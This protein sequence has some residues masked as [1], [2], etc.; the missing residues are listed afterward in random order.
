MKKKILILF[1]LLFLI[2]GCKKDL[3]SFT[4]AYTTGSTI[5]GYTSSSE[6]TVYHDGE[7][8]DHVE[9]LETIKS[10]NIDVLSSIEQ[11]IKNMYDPLIKKYKGYSY[12]ID[13]SRDKII[14]KVKI[15]YTK[16]DI[17]AYLRD[18]PSQ[19]NYF[20]GDK[21]SVDGIVAI[22]DSMGIGCDYEKE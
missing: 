15:D 11:S 6:Y 3:Q 18:N 2:T 19:E 16:M 9:I 17:T 1:C 5:T 22:Y 14:S 10:D 12:D 20:L 7:F 21:L 8:V 4:C 13:R